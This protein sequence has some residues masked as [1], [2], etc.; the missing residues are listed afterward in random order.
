MSTSR[1]RCFLEAL[2][3]PPFDSHSVF[4][5]AIIT[6]IFSSCVLDAT[7]IVRGSDP[8]VSSVTRYY[9][10]KSPIR[11]SRGLFVCLVWRGPPYFHSP[12]HRSTE[13]AYLD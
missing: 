2:T 5:D 10:D 11:G 3:A 9:V 8:V 13:T 12:V 1:R 6:C 4:L 7:Q